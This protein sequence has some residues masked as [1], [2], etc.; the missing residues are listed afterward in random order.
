MENQGLEG[1]EKT[2]IR[3]KAPKN[4]WTSVEWAERKLQQLVLCF[5]AYTVIA[6]SAQTCWFR[7]QLFFFLWKISWRYRDLC[8]VQKSILKNAQLRFSTIKKC[9]RKWFILKRPTFFRSILL[10]I[11]SRLTFFIHSKITYK[12]LPFR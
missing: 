5:K 10:V 1:E 2:R 7:P 4:E 12:F 9:P 6:W 8:D 3:K 11:S